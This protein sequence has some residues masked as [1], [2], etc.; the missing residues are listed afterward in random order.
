MSK[1]RI[2]FLGDLDQLTRELRPGRGRVN[3]LRLGDKWSRLIAPGEIVELVHQGLEGDTVM[4]SAK[5]VELATGQF[6][7][8]FEKYHAKNHAYPEDRNHGSIAGQR[9][10]LQSLAR[11]YD[12]NGIAPEQFYTVIVLE[13]F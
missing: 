4:W 8:L 7:G 10:V 3:T 12:V 1:K 5:V 13:S 6:A 9:V 2:L 11:A